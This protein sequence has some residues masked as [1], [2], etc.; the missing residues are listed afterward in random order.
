MLY[1]PVII[2]EK[3]I[4]LLEIIEKHEGQVTKGML[5]DACSINE[6]WP[7]IKELIKLGLIAEDGDLVQGWGEHAFFLTNEGLAFLSDYRAEL[8]KKHKEKRNTF[9]DS[10]IISSV[11]AWVPDLIRLIIE[12]F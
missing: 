7:R 9:V 6:N 2:P 12:L 4:E 3:T 11:V 10:A 5:V 8:K 1:S